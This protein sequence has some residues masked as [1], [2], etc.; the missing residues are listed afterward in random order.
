MENT[1]ETR[2][3]ICTEQ[4]QTTLLPFP[5]QYFGAYGKG[6]KALGLKIDAAYKDDDD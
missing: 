4:G 6:L 2:F 3:C 1:I 5:K